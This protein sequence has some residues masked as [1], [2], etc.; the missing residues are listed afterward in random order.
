MKHVATGWRAALIDSNRDIRAGWRI[1]IIVVV[2]GIRRV[3]TGV[4]VRKLL[5]PRRICRCH[6][7][8]D[9]DNR[10]NRGRAI[11]GHRRRKHQYQAAAHDERD[12][13]MGHYEAGE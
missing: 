4:V 1:I 11:G 8:E 6:A 12:R 2:G 10:G 5:F 7:N 13:E 3:E 9:R